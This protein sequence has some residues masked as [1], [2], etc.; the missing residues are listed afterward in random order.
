MLPGS[1]YHHFASKEELLA[2]VYEEGVRRIGEAVTTAVA[3]ETDPWRRLETACVAHLE[4]LLS[5]GDYAQVVIRVRPSD[6][7]GIAERLIAL[8]DG[9]E[10][11]FGDL[12]APLP[13]PPGTDRRYLRLLLL[14]A[15]NWSQ[16]WFR[17]GGDPPSG[18]ARQFLGLLRR[19]LE[20]S[21]AAPA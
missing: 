21:P 4:V 13:L 6:A 9:Y 14:G 16:T 15:L 17:P 3:A 12:I 5:G 8:R 11:L 10:R 7:P 19:S 18:I 20:R 2:A 1:L